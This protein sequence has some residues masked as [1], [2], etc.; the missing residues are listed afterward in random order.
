MREESSSRET[1]LDWTQLG[2]VSIC[3]PGRNMDCK[4]SV[5]TLH[6]TSRD[7]DCDWNNSTDH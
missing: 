1:W 3:N 6:T 4:W 7:V 2:E 5:I